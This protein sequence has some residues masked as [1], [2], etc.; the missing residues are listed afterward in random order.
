VTKKETFPLDA[1]NPNQREV[2]EA[3]NGPILVLAGAGSGKTRVLTYRI[4][5]LIHEMGVHPSEILA[6]TFTNKAASEMKER[7]GKITKLDKSLWIGTFHSIFARVLRIEAQNLG[8]HPDFVIYDADDQERLVK[9]ILQENDYA[10]SQY[11]PK[12]VLFKISR[13]KSSLTDPSAF[14]PANNNPFEEVVADIY[15][16]YQNRLKAHNAFDFDDL[17]VSPIR[18]FENKTD[19]LEKYRSRMRYIMVDEYQDTNRA[20]YQL[21]YLL[22]K[23]HRNLFVVGDDDQSIYRWRGADL[24]NILEFEK[25]FSDTKVFRLEQNYRSTQNILKAANS[26]VSRNIGRKEKTLWAESEAGENV[27]ITEVRDEREEAAKVIEKIQEEVFQKKRPFRDFVILYRTNAQS[28]VL[29]DYLR[30]NGINY[31][32]VGGVRFY[33]RKEIKDILAYLKLI[34]NPKDEVSLNRIINF[35]AR[36]IGAVSLQKLKAWANSNGLDL[37]H[38]LS[39]AEKI[40][41]IIQRIKQSMHRFY[42]LIQ[43]Y[44]E[45]KDQITLNELIH[46]LIDETGL[47]SMYKTDTT[48]EGQ[49]RK[50]NIQEFLNAVNDYVRSNKQAG[51]RDFLEEVALVTDVDNWDEKA[52]A[53][54]LMTLHCAKGLEFPVVMITGLEDALLPISR[55]LDNP[56]DLEEERRL[57]YVGLTR[58]K[59]KIYLFYAM[60][61]NFMNDMAYRLPSRFLDDLDT[62]V[63]NWTKTTIREYGKSV[64]GRTPYSEDTFYEP[65]PDYESF[66][67]DAEALKSGT[68]IE[69]EIYGRG[70]VV[71]IEGRNE[72]QK[73]TVRFDSGVEKKFL[74]KYAKFTIV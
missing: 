27:D 30:R 42:Q 23:I 44:I 38:A 22:A 18:L 61:R 74:T 5:Y 12:S 47:L 72:K 11:A 59:E 26:V 45:L 6:M 58:A 25:D 28:R 40:E 2:V 7:I 1:L 54:T 37:F 19:I 10:I 36:G 68:S 66:S 17:L 20:Q 67:Q 55:S 69:H 32:I 14:K 62:S 57:F 35:P 73:A 21:I 53:V 33:E 65:H 16:K 52:N 41:D 29:E 70:R 24:R 34:M 71:R 15:P 64:C 51:L 49:M 43:K 3:E 39:Q 9:S 48:V 4:A 13:L 56:E 63:I 8:Y 60:Q 31:V 50:E 46:T